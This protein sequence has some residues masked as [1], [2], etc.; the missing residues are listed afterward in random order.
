MRRLALVSLLAAACS[1]PAPAD[2]APAP[3]RAAE[4]APPPP[5]PDLSEKP[6]P[7][8][9]AEPPPPADVGALLA[10][11][12]TEVPALADAAAIV[13][14]VE[15][16]GKVPGVAEAKVG[17]G[18][19][20]NFSLTLTPPQD[21]RDLAGRLGWTGAHAVSGDVHQKRFA[22]RLF[23]HEL[24]DKRSKRIA[25][26]SPRLGPFRVDAD[27]SARPAGKLPKVSAGAS[28][29]YDLATY[30]ATV[31]RLTFTRDGK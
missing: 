10:A 1:G 2:P 29:A 16:I 30:E 26:N 18:P 15:R 8:A 6:A 9:P 7:P 11:M 19:Q 13:R 3:A 21:A 14:Y 28:P 17:P 23:S 24:P 20:E 25:T 31:E 4:P 5:A 22:I 12:P 27:L